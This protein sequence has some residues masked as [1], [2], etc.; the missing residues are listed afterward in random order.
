[1]TTSGAV[2]TLA[3]HHLTGRPNVPARSPV[4]LAPRFRA[5]A[6]RPTWWDQSLATTGH[7]PTSD[8]TERFWLGVLGPSVIC[9]LRRITRGFEAHPAG[10]Q[11]VLADTARAIGL[12]GGTGQQAPINRTIDRACTFNMARRTSP[13]QLEVRLHMPTLTSRQLSRLP[14]RSEPHTASGSAKTLRHSRGR[15]APSPPRSRFPRLR[16]STTPADA[17]ACGRR[18]RWRRRNSRRRCLK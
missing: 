16:C 14:L 18:S 13:E 2:S 4:R 12:G 3:G 9:L 10:F 15:A 17:G 8:Y 5:N 1:M 11:I 7:S 6:H